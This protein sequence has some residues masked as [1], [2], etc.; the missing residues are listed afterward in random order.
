MLDY[1]SEDRRVPPYYNMMSSVV[2]P[3]LSN[4]FA[5]LARTTWTGV[6]HDCLAEPAIIIP[7]TL[8]FSVTTGLPLSPASLNFAVLSRVG[9]ITSWSVNRASALAKATQATPF[10]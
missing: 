3:E 5:S 4:A 9:S 7:A 1:I 2:F 8:C 10:T 6:A